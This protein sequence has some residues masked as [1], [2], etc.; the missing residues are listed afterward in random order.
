M[1]TSM[2]VKEYIRSK[3]RLEKLHMTLI[4]P[5]KLTPKECSKMAQLAFRAGTDAIMVG[6]STGID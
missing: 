2:R 3:L 6:G 1:V 5:D 4:D